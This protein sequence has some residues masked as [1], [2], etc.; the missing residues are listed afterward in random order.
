MDEEGLV[1]VALLRVIGADLNGHEALGG[2]TSSFGQR[3]LQCED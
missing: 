3:S 1:D 2:D